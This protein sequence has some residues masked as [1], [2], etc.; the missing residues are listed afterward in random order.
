[1]RH[2]TTRRKAVLLGGL[3]IL[4]ILTMGCS[5]CTMVRGLG[6]NVALTAVATVQTQIAEGGTGPPRLQPRKCPRQ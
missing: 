6:K 4:A 3:L 2:N 5:L 1:M